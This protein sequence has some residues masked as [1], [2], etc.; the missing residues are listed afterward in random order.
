MSPEATFSRRLAPFDTERSVV[1][2]ASR[3]DELLTIHAV[4]AD[5]D[6][7]VRVLTAPARARGG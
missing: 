2:E 7:L 3:A 1:R 5:L 4:L 6:L